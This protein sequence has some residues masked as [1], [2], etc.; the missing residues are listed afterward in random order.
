MSRSTSIVAAGVACDIVTGAGT[1]TWPLERSS[2]VYDELQPGSYVF[3]DVDYAGN[4]LGAEDVRFEQSL[5]VLS[6]VMSVP[7]A[8][9]AIADAGLKAFSFD[10]G[11]PIVH[12]TA[13][14]EYR[15]ASDEHGVI[16]SRKVRACP[17]SASAYGSCQVTAIRR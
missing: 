14:L 17:R 3:M 12:G 1:G 9:R 5:F 2:G 13:G 7:S 6:A 4:T 16:A 8:Q 15:K 11:L 10:A